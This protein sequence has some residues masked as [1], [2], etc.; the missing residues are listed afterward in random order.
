MT[1]VRLAF[2]CRTV[3]P[4]DAT[5]AWGARWIINQQGLVD[6]LPDR[7]DCDGP[8]GE[9][10]KLLDY[11]DQHVGRQPRDVLCK[12]LSSGRLSTRSDDVVTLF[13]DG[14]VKVAGS[15][16]GSAGYFYVSAFWSPPA[17]T[18][19]REVIAEALAHTTIGDGWKVTRGLLRNGGPCVEILAPSGERYVAIVEMDDL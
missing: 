7:Q 4:D 1:D 19:E 10:R 15:P 8:T 14:V 9:R 6:Q 3:L 18:G 16:Q 13:D 5:V 17:P 2:G 11:L 12:L